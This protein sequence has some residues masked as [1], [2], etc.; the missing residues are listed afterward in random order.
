MEP[1]LDGGFIGV[2]FITMARP[3]GLQCCCLAKLEIAG[4]QDPESYE[5]L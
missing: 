5:I 2:G 4:N 1:A 3:T